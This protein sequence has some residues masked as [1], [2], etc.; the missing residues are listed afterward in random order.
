MLS[1]PWLLILCGAGLLLAGCRARPATLEQV[2]KQEQQQYVRESY[3]T[4]R[5]QCF[6]DDDLTSFK[7]KNTLAD[8]EQRLRQ[9]RDFI[10]IVQGLKAK[11]EPERHA[12]LLAARNAYQP[13][14]EELG[15]ISSEGQTRAGQE[16]QRMICTAIVDLTDKLLTLPNEEL[17]KMAEQ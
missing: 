10:K 3:G 9:S 14:W 15:R 5:Y 4:E 11:P 12:L 2:I 17:Q 1:K 8:I 7:G 16:A 13:S 6:T